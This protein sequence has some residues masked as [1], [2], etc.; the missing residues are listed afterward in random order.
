MLL[1][2]HGSCC[3]VDL[4]VS[5]STC[6]LCTSET[7]FKGFSI[8]VFEHTFSTTYNSTHTIHTTHTHTTHTYTKH[9]YTCTT[10]IYNTYIH[11]THTHNTHTQHTHTKHTHN[12][13]TQH[14]HTQHTQH[15][16]TTHTHNTH[17]HNTHTCPC[18]HSTC[19]VLWIGTCLEPLFHSFRVLVYLSYNQCQG[20]IYLRSNF[21]KLNLS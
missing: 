5:D 1:S 2:M 21:A 14:T 16:H 17:T 3:H 11:N 20:I 12:T 13:H 8:F 18:I 6:V 7:K 19:F 10:H 4:C 9:T 15:T